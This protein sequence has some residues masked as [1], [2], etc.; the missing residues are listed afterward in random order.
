MKAVVFWDVTPC[1]FVAA[2]IFRAEDNKTCSSAMLVTSY[3]NMLRHTPE[4]GNL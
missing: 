3:Q 4:G 2:S 1:D